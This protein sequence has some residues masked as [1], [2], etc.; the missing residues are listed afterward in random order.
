MY[1]LIISHTWFRVNLHLDIVPVLSKE[2]LKIQL[3][4]ECR[5]TLKRVRYMIRNI[6]SDDILYFANTMHRLLT[7]E[8]TSLLLSQ[9]A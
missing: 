1:V 2:F 9:S 7:K 8:A 3:T 4:I 6:V 5:F